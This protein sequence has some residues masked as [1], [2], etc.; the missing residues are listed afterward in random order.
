VFADERVATIPSG[1]SANAGGTV[2]GCWRHHPFAWCVVVQMRDD[3][4]GK[5]PN[6]F[7]SVQPFIG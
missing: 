5:W 2:R 3:V 4:K 1:R 6:N 7:R